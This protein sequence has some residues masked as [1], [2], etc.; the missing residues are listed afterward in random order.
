MSFRSFT[1]KTL[2]IITALIVIFC[3]NV[4]AYKFGKVEDEH[5]QIGPP[6]DYPE[7]DAIII[8]DKADLVVGREK[9]VI[10]YHMRIKIL[11]QAG[12]EDVGEWEISYYKE[13]DKLK[14]F[15]AHTITPDGKKHKVEKNAI[16]GKAYY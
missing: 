4:Q 8:F 5:W 7:A 14:G 1:C 6:T 13:Y 2:I 16:F 3:L 15:K 9:V 11:T 10:D 12:I